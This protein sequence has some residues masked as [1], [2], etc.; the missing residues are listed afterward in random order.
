[1]GFIKDSS[2]KNG[3]KHT[4]HDNSQPYSATIFLLAL[5]YFQQNKMNN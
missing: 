3:P 4:A 2:E 5:K 1:M